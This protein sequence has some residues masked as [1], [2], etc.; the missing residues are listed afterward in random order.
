MDKFILLILT[1]NNAY[2]HME[3]KIIRLVYENNY[4]YLNSINVNFFNKIIIIYFITGII[5]MEIN[6]DWGLGPIPNPQSPI[7][8]PHSIKLQCQY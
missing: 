3:R 4:F 5:K 1:L 8:N 2:L 7:P 6:G